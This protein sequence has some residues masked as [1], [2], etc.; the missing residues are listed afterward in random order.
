MVGNK[1][2]L[3]GVDEPLSWI[4]NSGNGKAVF[5][6]YIALGR[7]M[8]NSYYQLHGYEAQIYYFDRELSAGEI[9]GFYKFGNKTAGI[10]TS[11]S[12]SITLAW[13]KSAFATSYEVFLDDVSQGVTTDTSMTILGISYD[14]TY[15]WYVVANNSYG[16]ATSETNSF[17][18]P[19]V[20]GAFTLTSPT[21]SA[22]NVSMNPTLTWTSA[23][24]ATSYEVFL[25]NTSQGTT[26]DTSMTISGLSFNTTYTWYVVA[27]NPYGATTSATESFTTVATLTTV[28]LRLG[29]SDFTNM[30]L[31]NA[32]TADQG[33][34]TIYFQDNDGNNLSFIRS[35]YDAQRQSALY[36]VSVPEASTID[37]HVKTDSSSDLASSSGDCVDW[38][39]P[40][41]GN[42][43]DYSGHRSD[44]V[45]SWIGTPSYTYESGYVR[46]SQSSGYNSGP[47]FPAPNLG[48]SIFYK[49]QAGTW[50][51][52]YIATNQNILFEPSM[53]NTT[54][55]SKAW[56]TTTSHTCDEYLNGV[57]NQSVGPKS[58]SRHFFLMYMCS[59]CYVNFY[60]YIRFNRN[61]TATEISALYNNHGY[62]VNVL[63]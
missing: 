38:R 44:S 48:D 14:T 50:N 21:N 56:V 35:A 31:A 33:A 30:G 57:Y 60:E 62:T 4:A 22:T 15:N 41:R 25:N 63:Y 13:D 10:T 29:P 39:I 1:M 28:S 61:L 11:T 27:S 19:G 58:Y 16:S 32:T 59:G 3:N 2:Y 49:A 45:G 36:F 26:T 37:I 34:T 7:W 8:I 12:K 23:D 55:K 46:I 42:M 24:Y 20:P 51:T 52:L 54:L 43:H 5:K 6:D 9:Y 17:T 40:A 18:T 53:D 47:T